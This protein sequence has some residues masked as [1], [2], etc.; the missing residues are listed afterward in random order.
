MDK[1]KLVCLL[2][3]IYNTR[4]HT[5]FQQY[6]KR[7]GGYAALMTVVIVL[8]AGLTIVGS[9]AFFALNEA[10]INRAYV[11][12]VE[13]GTAAESGMEDMVYRLVSG[14]QTAASDTLAVG[15]AVAETTLTQNGSERIIRSEG[16]R[17]NYHQS[18]EARMDV[19]ADSVSFF[20]GVQVGAGGMTMDSNAQIDGNVFS[21]GSVTGSAGA[22]VTG[23]AVVATGL[24]AAPSAEWPAGCTDVCGNA[25]HLFATA[26][27][28]RD[29]AQSFIASATGALNKISVLLGKNGSPGADITLRVAPDVGGRPDTAQISN[30]SAVISRAAV[31][32]APAWIDVIFET[33]PDVT[34]GAKYWILLDYGADSAVHNWDWRKDSAD[35]YVGNTG[36]TTANW[37]AKNPVWTD[38]EG[39]LVFR[40]WIGGVNTKMAEVSVGGTARAP[41]FSNVSAGGSGCPNPNCVVASDP[42]QA[43]PITDA[44]IQEWRDKAAA[45]GVIEGTYTVTSSVSLGPKK[46]AGDLNLTANNKTLTV[47]GTIFVQGNISIDNGSTIRCDSEY[48]VSSCVVLADGWIHTKNNGVFSGSGTAGSY[49]MLLSAAPCDGVSVAPPCDTAHH[50]AAIDL[51]N[52]AAGVIFYAS[53]GLANAHNNVAVSELTAYKISLDN[54]TTIT[55]ESGLADAHFTSGPSGGYDIKYWK[56]TE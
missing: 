52:N 50:N 44:K 38:A 47:T 8:G 24:A 22:A 26:G 9:F 40:L 48:G 30:G 18:M 5:S 23:A 56:N 42:A 17:E 46:I 16:V 35:G 54:N 43:L 34:G 2:A 4:M 21:N 33:S 29:I 15:N 32:A 51:H 41:V 53:R 55:Y 45:G 37:S 28:N 6:G 13:A 12:A 36:K 10:R 39:D 14:K 49:I 7:R 3:A 31:S 1:T 27:D 25:D 11:K 19:A 20:Y